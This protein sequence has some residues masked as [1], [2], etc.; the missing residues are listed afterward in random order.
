MNTILNDIVAVKIPDT[1]D[2][3]R[4]TLDFDFVTLHRLLNSGADI[5]NTYIDTRFLQKVN[6]SP[7]D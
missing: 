4:L 7:F 5:A 6:A 1:L 2:R 3:Y